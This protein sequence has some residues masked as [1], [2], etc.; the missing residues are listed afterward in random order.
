MLY[1]FKS[2]GDLVHLDPCD[3]DTRINKGS[4]ACQECVYNV[5][6]DLKNNVIN[7]KLMDNETETNR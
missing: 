6:T 7:C 1:K 4:L 3:Y 5:D 2:T